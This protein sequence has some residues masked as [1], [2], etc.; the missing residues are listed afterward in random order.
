[1]AIGSNNITSSSSYERTMSF[2]S[3]SDCIP[4]LVVLITES[5]AI[6]IL[7][8]ITIIVFVKQR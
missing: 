6:V 3:S 1:M 8:M 7:N 5:L 2:L 4:W